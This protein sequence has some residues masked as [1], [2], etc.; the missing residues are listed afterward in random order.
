MANGTTVVIVLDVVLDAIA[1]LGKA[2]D[3]CIVLG[4]LR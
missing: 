2:S 3:N 4:G 1:D